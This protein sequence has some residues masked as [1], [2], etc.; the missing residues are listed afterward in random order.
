MVK[1]FCCAIVLRG[2]RTLEFVYVNP[3][4][5]HFMLV[6]HFFTKSNA[7]NKGCVAIVY[8]KVVGIHVCSVCEIAVIVVSQING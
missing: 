3:G 1:K 4:I 7:D 2:I 8:M 5:S 6:T